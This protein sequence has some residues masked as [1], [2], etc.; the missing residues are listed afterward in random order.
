MEEPI[1]VERLLA[2]LAEADSEELDEE[3]TA[4]ILASAVEEGA[5]LSHDEMLQ[6]LGL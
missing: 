1:E 5:S 6:R 2:I 4:R 3:T